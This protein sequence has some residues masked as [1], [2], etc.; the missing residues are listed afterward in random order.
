M[1]ADIRAESAT[2]RLSKEGRKLGHT[3]ANL[4][5]AYPGKQPS[6]YQTYHFDFEYRRN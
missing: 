3:A 5:E 2:W 4:K 6:R 1:L